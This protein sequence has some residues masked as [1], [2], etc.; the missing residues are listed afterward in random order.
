M[1][2]ELLLKECREKGMDA[3]Q[4]YQI[5]QGL[6]FG[7]SE[8]EIRLFAKKELDE[9]QMN[10][11]RLAIKHRLSEEEIAFLSDTRFNGHQMEQIVTGLK[12]G[13]TLEKVKQYAKEEL[14]AHEM[15]RQR[16]DLLRNSVA[17]TPSIFS[18]EYYD[19]MVRVSE[20][21]SQQ[22]EQM[23]T[24]FSWLQEFI[25]KQNTTKKD[26]GA[27]EKLKAYEDK[28]Q[29]IERENAELKQSLAEK[30]K[31]IAVMIEKNGQ[32][33]GSFFA[34]FSKKKNPLTIM[35]LM[36]NPKFQEKQ[37][38]QIRL[39]YEHGLALDEILHYARPEF[40]DN[41]MECIRSV[42]ENGKKG[43]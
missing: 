31:W 34:R 16:I 10:S 18:K 38:M 3:R 2:E 41:R 33:A 1:E 39:G 35:E 42:L 25:L 6:E 40:D 5:Q 21:Q 28:I 37:L 24:H 7:L 12:D 4:L 15:C 19:H 23:N 14:S 27:E 30:E 8:K 20:K 43:A 9:L 32:K 29:T 22:L 26:T 13:L 36:G 11:I 17:D